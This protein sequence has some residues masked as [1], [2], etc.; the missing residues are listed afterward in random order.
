M[1]FTAVLLHAFLDGFNTYLKQAGE[2]RAVKCCHPSTWHHQSFCRHHPSVLL[3]PWCSCYKSSHNYHQRQVSSCAGNHTFSSDVDLPSDSNCKTTF[4]HL[5]EK[6]WPQSN[7][8]VSVGWDSPGQT[9]T[10][11]SIEEAET[12]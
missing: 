4:S 11:H 7:E 6:D 8:V 1:C 5:S 3:S 12:S 9:I 10:S 2:G